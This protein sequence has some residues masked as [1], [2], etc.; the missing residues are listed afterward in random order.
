MSSNTC[1][2]VPEIQKLEDDLVEAMRMNNP[3]FLDK[4]FSE[5][6]V[7]LGSD[8]STWGKEKALDDFKHP[9]F[10]LSE[11]DIHSRRIT[12]HD[13]SAIVTGISVLKGK[14]GKESITGRYLFM[15]VWHKSEKGWEIIAVKTNKVK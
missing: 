13:N 15:R 8:G 5:K 10:Q 4:I 9:E 1:N 7:F 3:A 12:M 11:I 6:Y 2:S 14:I